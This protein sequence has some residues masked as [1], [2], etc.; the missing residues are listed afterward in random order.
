VRS[1]ALGGGARTTGGACGVATDLGSRMVGESYV[2]FPD[3][4]TFDCDYE[5]LDTWEADSVE[6]IERD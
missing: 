5:L 3:V 1:A 6:M 4:Y 2:G